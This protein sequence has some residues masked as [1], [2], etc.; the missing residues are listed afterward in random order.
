MGKAR[1]IRFDDDTDDLFINPNT[2][3][4]DITDSDTRHVEDIVASFAGWWKEFPTVGVGI[5][6]FSGSSGGIQR[7]KR[8]VKIQLEGDGY[9]VSDISIVDNNLY[10]T[11]E[12]KDESI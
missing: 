5:K 3:D 11:G 1:D 7:V 10:I 12:R 2:G 4:F 6:N 9:R 8:E